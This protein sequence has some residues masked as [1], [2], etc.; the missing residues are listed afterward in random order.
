MAHSKGFSS[1]TFHKVNDLHYALPMFWPPTV[2]KDWNILKSMFAL[3]YLLGQGH[4]IFHRTVARY[5]ITGLLW[6]KC[7]APFCQALH[8]K[9]FSSISPILIRLTINQLLCDLFLPG[10]WQLSTYVGKY[11]LAHNSSIQ[12]N[13]RSHTDYV[14]A[15]HR[16]PSRMSVI[17]SKSVS[18]KILT[19]GC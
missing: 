4:R 6:S 19:C 1:Y 10:K 11:W 7:E 9:L 13:H 15:H 14:T 16:Q 18:K 5:S 3:T 12:G 17:W 2:G 8:M